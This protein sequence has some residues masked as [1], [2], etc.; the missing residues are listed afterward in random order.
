MIA[1][2]VT[3]LSAAWSVVDGFG[4]CGSE[5]EH[6]VQYVDCEFDLSD[7]RREVSAFE[8]AADEQMGSV[9]PQRCHVKASTPV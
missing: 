8:S 6:S 2:D 3:I 7:L 4:S 9:D 1:R 5:F